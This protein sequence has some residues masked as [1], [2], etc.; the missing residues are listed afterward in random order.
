VDYRSWRG[1]SSNRVE[2]FSFAVGAGA[3]WE[4]FVLGVRIGTKDRGIKRL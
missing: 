2:L 4:G 1:K 3:Q